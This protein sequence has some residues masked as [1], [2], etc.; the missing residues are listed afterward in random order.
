MRFLV[1]SVAMYSTWVYS[2]EFRTLFDCGEGVATAM[3][4]KVYAVDR[5]CLS[6]GHMDHIGGLPSFLWARAG[7]R[8]DSSK[9]LTVCH[10]DS[11]SLQA[12]RS[13][14]ATFE[15]RLGYTIHWV[16]TQPG[17]RLPIADG[18]RC[19]QTYRAEHA[20]EPAVGYQVLEERLRLKPEHARDPGIGRKLAGLT[21]E[22]K[23]V[24]QERVPLA[25]LAYSGDSMPIDPAIIAGCRCLFFDAT[26]LREEDR[27]AP[28]HA[29]LREAFELAS[30]ARVRQLYAF[31]L[32]TRYELPDIDAAEKEY[33]ALNPPFGFH[34][35]RPD[36]VH[37]I[38]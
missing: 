10:P 17:H 8:G 4:N 14:V 37:T 33:L 12:L 32:S 35:I 30:Q 6:H 11:P 29:S 23:A 5:I 31:H 38:D 34:I 20:D 27:K 24:Y 15:D 1:H 2:Q 21:A 9:P 7:A 19:I 16:Q 25:L 22:E 36:G 18:R 26:F 13:Y 28:L 3:Q